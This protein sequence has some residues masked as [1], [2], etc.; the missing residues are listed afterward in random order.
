MKNPVAAE[1]ASA[2]ID[3]KIKDLGDWRAKTFTKVRDVIHQ[4]NPEYV[5]EVKS[6]GTPVFSHGGIV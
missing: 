1:S 6:M 2:F 4:A 3:Q 5:E